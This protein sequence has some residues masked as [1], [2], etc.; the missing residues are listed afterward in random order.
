MRKRIITVFIVLFLVLAMPVTSFAAWPAS[1]LSDS[2]VKML[3]DIFIL[4]NADTGEIIMSK[5]AN[6]R[7]APA[8]LT[9]IAAAAVVLQ[10]YDDLTKRVTVLQSDFDAIYGT[11]SSVSGL[12]AGEVR[13]LRELL[14]C[15]LIP[16]GNDAAEVLM[17]YLGGHEVFMEK[18]NAF[19]ESAGCTDTHFLNA[20]GLDE[21]GHY[22]T[23]ADILKMT[24]KAMENP[25]FAELSSLREFELPAR[26]NI[27][28]R[29]IHTTNRLVNPAIPDYYVPHAAGIKTGNTEEAGL[30]LVSFARHSGYSYYTVVMGGRIQKHSSKSYDINTA[31]FDTKSLFDWAFDSLRLARVA[32]PLDVIHQT[33]LLYA[34]EGDRMPL[35]PANEIYLLVPEGVDAGGLL[36]LPVTDTVPEKFEAPVQKNTS[37]GLAK[38][39]YAQQEIATIELVTQIDAQ[40]SPFLYAVKI[41]GDIVGSLPFRLLAAVLLLLLAGYIVFRYLR[42]KKQRGPRP[43]SLPP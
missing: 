26:G 38:V 2:G 43:V 29:T 13:T 40:R 37:A 41:I 6:R 30:C 17:R 39:L 1:I 23:A 19:A 10:E 18:M 20:H 32:T 27:P 14:A 8:S 5:D 16:S 42:R 4:A 15:L 7:V 33:E 35:C 11:N 31:L 9:K 12:K 22:S 3:S 24:I 34:K 25:V 28:A 36:I 21:A